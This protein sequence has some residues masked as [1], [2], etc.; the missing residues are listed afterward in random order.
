MP[1]LHWFKAVAIMSVVSSMPTT[2]TK[3]VNQEKRTGSARA[4]LSP[5][6]T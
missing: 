4:E 2:T 6:Q 1:V 5:S 3:T